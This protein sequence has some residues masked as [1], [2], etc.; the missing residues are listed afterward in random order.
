MSRSI[1]FYNRYTG[2]LETETIYGESYLRWTYENPFGRLAL[3]VLVKRS[4]FNAW[5]GWRM[6]RPGSRGKVEPFID[7]YEI[8]MRECRRSGDSFETFNDFFYRELTAEA[9]PIARS[10]G[11]VS[12]PADGR[13]MAIPDLSRVESIY[14][15]GQAFE[16]ETFLGSDEL[17]GRFSGGSVVIS[18]L[19]PVDYHR[20]HSPVSGTLV[21][22]REIDGSLY[23]VSPIALCRKVGYLWENKRVLTTI[24]TEAYGLVAFVAIGATCVG[25]IHMTRGK[26]ARVEQGEELGYFA[27]GGSCVATVFEKS[28]IA[29]EPDL[30]EN[31]SRETEVY[32]KMGDRLG[33]AVE[34]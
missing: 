29:L 26:G 22:Q 20:F 16:L 30:V 27:F 3:N 31:S 28:R 32:A 19:C 2:A 8:D 5:Y 13:H 10:D 17:A 24:Q 21:E 34:R 12:L 33:T 18:R 6:D 4:L 23:S 7:Q 15:K 14:V 25:R 11:I 1:Q 9:R